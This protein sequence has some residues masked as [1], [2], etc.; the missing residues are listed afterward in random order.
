MSS[1]PKHKRIERMVAGALAI[2]EQSALDAGALGFMARA[3][4]QATMPHRSIPQDRFIRTNGNYEL[5]M[6]AMRNDIGLP[7]GSMPRLILAWMGTEAVKTQERELVLGD[8]MT[9]FMRQLGLVPYGGRWGTI[10]RLK[11]QTRRLLNCGITCSYTREHSNGT[12]EASTKMMVAEDSD[13]WW[14]IANNID[15]QRSLFKSTIKLSERFFNE[16]ISHPVPVDMRTLNELKRSPMALDIYAWLTWRMSYLNKATTIP[17]EGLQAQFGAGYP[18]TNRGKQDFKAK[19]K[20]HLK[21][22]LV[23]YTDAKVDADT[24]GLTLKPSLTHITTSPI[25][26]ISTP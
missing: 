23:Y 21:D 24:G 6:V 7:Y 16:I 12:N 26:P 17:W 15:E 13:F 25:P 22:V 1:S 14:P 10:T 3:L 20:K 11:D 5:E 19:F 9:E 4:V 18:M 8:N 2:E